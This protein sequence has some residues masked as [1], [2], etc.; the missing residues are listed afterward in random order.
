MGYS[1]NATPCQWG[2]VAVKLWAGE[3]CNISE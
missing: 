3:G 2:K 1:R